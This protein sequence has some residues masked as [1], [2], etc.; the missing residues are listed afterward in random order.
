MNTISVSNYFEKFLKIL[1]DP[2]N[3][4]KSQEQLYNELE[5]WH[6]KRTGQNK[7]KSYV[8]FRNLKSQW[9]KANRP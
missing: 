4:D 3:R 9:Y 5:I 8:S 1:I 7:C 6:Q 2:K